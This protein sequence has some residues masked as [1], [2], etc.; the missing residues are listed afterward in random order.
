M[1]TNSDNQHNKSTK[2]NNSLTL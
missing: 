1:D 2:V